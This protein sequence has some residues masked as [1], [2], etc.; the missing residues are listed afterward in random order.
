[1]F[2]EQ[3]S[4]VKIENSSL[5]LPNLHTPASHF[6]FLTFLFQHL[7]IQYMVCSDV[8]TSCT[9]TCV[10]KYLCGQSFD[11]FFFTSATYVALLSTEA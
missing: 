6:L 10:K 5:I 11:E 3:V 1:M 2:I 7:Y 8:R 9:T 4:L